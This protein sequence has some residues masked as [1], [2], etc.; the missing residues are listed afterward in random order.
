MWIIL[1]THTW[2]GHPLSV[3]GKTGFYH[4]IPILSV[5]MYVQ[6]LVDR[7]IQ[8]GRFPLFKLKI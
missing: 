4:P 6:L 3:P 5:T 8:F 7:N 1:G 2:K